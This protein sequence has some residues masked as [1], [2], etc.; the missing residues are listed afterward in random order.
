MSVKT[1]QVTGLSESLR[2]RANSIL[3]ILEDLEAQIATL[4]GSWDGQAK[5]AYQVAQRQWTT[6]A[7]RLQEL[8]TRIS[9]ATSQISQGYTTF[10]SRAAAQF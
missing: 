5:Q 3:S 8:A 9:Q 1:A 10:D 2:S 7:H 6:E 4:Q